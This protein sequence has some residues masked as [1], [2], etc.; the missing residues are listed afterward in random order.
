MDRERE[1]MTER[2]AVCEGDPNMEAGNRMD[3]LSQTLRPL[4]PKPE[5]TSL[6]AQPAALQT[7]KKKY[8]VTLLPAL[9][10]R[11]RKVAVFE[12]QA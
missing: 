6:S 3:L 9:C 4:K 2:T 12:C 11:E 7:D 10:V 1:G 5:L 8:S